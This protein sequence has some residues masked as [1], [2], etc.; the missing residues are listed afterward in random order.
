[1]HEAKLCL[2]LLRIAETHRVQAGAGR[3]TALRLRVGALSGV[4][5][6]ALARAFPICA[7]GTPADGAALRI[8]EEPGRAL[9]LADMEVI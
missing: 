2:A 5:P 8:E 7:A 3:I 6:E 9:Q 1:M 4:S